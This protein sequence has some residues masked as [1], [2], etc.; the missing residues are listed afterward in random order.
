MLTTFGALPAAVSAA[1]YELSGV[2]EEEMKAYQRLPPSWEKN[3]RL[4]PTGRDKKQNQLMK[5]SYSNPYDM[6]EKIAIAAINKAE[7]GQER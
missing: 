2:S 6:L 3:A 4:V 5:Y 1:S 7:Q